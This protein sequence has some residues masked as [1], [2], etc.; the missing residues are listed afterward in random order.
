MACCTFGWTGI[1]GLHPSYKSLTCGSKR[2]APANRFSWRT[3]PYE[4]V[5]LTRHH[6]AK[7]LLDAGHR[8]GRKSSQTNYNDLVFATKAS[9]LDGGHRLW[10]GMER[11]GL[12][13]A[14]SAL[15]TPHDDDNH[16]TTH[17]GSAVARVTKGR[18]FCC[19]SVGEK[20]ATDIPENKISARSNIIT[21]TWNV[22]TLREAGKLEELTHWMTR[23]LWNIL[24]LCEM[25]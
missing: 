3:K 11:D 20:C 8:P 9:H 25:R 21:G 16:Y 19:L 2:H 14:T 13:H 4:G 15:D 22:R 12:R 5:V 6:W 10:S 7:D 24:G 1:I 18:A 17:T 23:Y